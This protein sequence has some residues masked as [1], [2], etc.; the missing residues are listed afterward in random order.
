[1]NRRSALGQLLVAGAAP[2][3]GGCGR[4][5]S[6]DRGVEGR[7]TMAKDQSTTAAPNGRMPAI[8]LAHGSPLL[9]DDKG[10]VDELARWAKTMPRPKAVLMISAHWLD[11]PVTLGAT[12]TVPL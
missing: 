3:I 6:G 7:T 1:M 10:W 11:A 4:T 8:F 9:L 12:K 5:G 2:L